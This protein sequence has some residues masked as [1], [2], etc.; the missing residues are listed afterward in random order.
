MDREAGSDGLSR[1]AFVKAGVT[2]AAIA[3]VPLSLKAA[4]PTG[5]EK[6]KKGR[7]AGKALV[8]TRVLGRTGVE[9]SILNFGSAQRTNPRLLNAVYDAGIRY[10]DTADCYTRGKAERTVG[11]WMADKGNRSEFFIVTKDHPE[12]PDEWVE[13][14]DRRLEALQTDTIDLFFLHELGKGFQGGGE[15]SHR[16]W[17]KLKKWGKAADKL[18]ASGKVKFVGFST[19]T[20][21]PLRIALMNNA[22]AG[23]WVDA[24]MVAYDPQL[25]R[26]NKEFNKALDKCH[27]AGIGLICMKEMRAVKDAP[28]FLPEFKEMGLTSQQAVLH[29]VW[30][31]ERIASICSAMT[32]LKIVKENSEAAKK[33]KPLDPEKHGAVIG[34]YERYASGY[35]NG[36]DGRCGRAGGTQAALGEITRYLSYYEMDGCRDEARQGYARLTSE[37]RDWR[38]ADLT[39]ASQACVSKLDFAALLPRAE[40][41]LA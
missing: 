27:E 29:A 6:G 36:C 15:E 38:G 8:P 18:K 11:Q 3:G 21:V 5:Q 37:Q 26:E 10:I 7:K 35:C 2:A 40:E 32:S 23:G 33:F 31:D 20:A 41:K 39:A 14:I 22:A 30:S 13:M 12:T 4:G 34:L 1:R 17:P 24:I 28:K 9:V 25:V 19:H 16:K